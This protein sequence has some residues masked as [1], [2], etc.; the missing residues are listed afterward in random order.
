MMKLRLAHNWS[1]KLHLELDWIGIGQ[2]SNLI[3]FLV[4]KRQKKLR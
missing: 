4:G 2:T 1:K 3:Q